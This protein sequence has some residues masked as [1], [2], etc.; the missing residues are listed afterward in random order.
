MNEESYA[1]KSIVE[2]L[3]QIFAHRLGKNWRDESANID[4]LRVRKDYW[5]RWEG[6]QYKATRVEGSSDAY[7][8]GQ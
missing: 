8:L 6:S 1:G 4:R 5:I 3:N 2:I 7:D